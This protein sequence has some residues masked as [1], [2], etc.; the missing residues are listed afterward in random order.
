MPE[1]DGDIEEAELLV[2]PDLAAAAAE[3]EADVVT[4]SAGREQDESEDALDEVPS[5]SDDEGDE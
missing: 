1:A 4:G 5:A 2:P 3:G